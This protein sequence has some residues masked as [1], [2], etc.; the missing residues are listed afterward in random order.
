MHKLLGNLQANSRCFPK[1][2]HSSEKFYRTAGPTGPDKS[3]V[4]PV[5]NQSSKYGQTEQ[6]KRTQMWILLCKRKRERVRLKVLTCRGGLSV[7]A[8]KTV[9]QM[10]KPRACIHSYFHCNTTTTIAS[11]CVFGYFHKLFSF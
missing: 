7:S 8:R 2:L 1:I 3:Q 9:V 5:S 6:R 10:N 4:F 11:I